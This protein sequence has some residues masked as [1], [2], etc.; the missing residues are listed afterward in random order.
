[1]QP[2]VI[3]HNAACLRELNARIHET[4]RLRPHGPEHEAACKE[5]HEQYDQLAFPGGLTQALQRLRDRDKSLLD[6]AIHF[7]REDPQYFRSGYNKEEILRLLKSFILSTAQKN[8][9]GPLLIRSVQSGPC[10]IFMAY[11]R[12]ASQ[13]DS[14]ATTTA[15]LACSKSSDA[16]TRRRANHVLEV[17]KTHSPGFIGGKTTNA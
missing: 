16:E 5:F 6:E 17:L 1:M 8:T 11:A 13:L 10:R 2:S 14:T 4:F 9:L 12:L 3:L 7:L 15:L